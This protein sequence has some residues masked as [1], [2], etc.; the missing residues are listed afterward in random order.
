[1]RL[2]VNQLVK[3]RTRRVSSELIQFV[4]GN[5]YFREYLHMRCLGESANYIY[6]GSERDVASHTFF[7]Y[8]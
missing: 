5:N 3:R 7:C 4:I 8:D 6:C 2:N 1:M